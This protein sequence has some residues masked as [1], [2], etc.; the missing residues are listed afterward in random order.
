MFKQ[1]GGFWLYFVGI[2]IMFL[3]LFYLAEVAT[4]RFAL[5]IGG[6]NPT[7]RQTPKITSLAGKTIIPTT[8]GSSKGIDITKDYYAEITTSLGVI[9]VDLYERNA[10]NT[11]AN[12]IDLANSGYYNNTKFYKL[13]PGVAV[14]GGSKD[15][16]VTGGPGYTIPDET[17]WD[18]LDYTED[19]RVLLRA[20]G[21]TSAKKIA[22]IDLDKYVLVMANPRPNSAGSQFMILLSGKESI[23][24]LK[25]R[26]R[27]TVFGKVMEDTSVI[28][29]IALTQIDNSGSFPKPQNDITISEIK[30]YTK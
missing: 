2:I 18:S 25:L 9:K 30:I 27:V 15:N 23:D 24:V 26:G 5:G 11:V 4:G 16:S 14:Q 12:F 6:T 13:L 28:Q 7:A 1:Q 8:N 3:V 21:Y 20:E 29:K 19:L 10:P 17:N 22:S